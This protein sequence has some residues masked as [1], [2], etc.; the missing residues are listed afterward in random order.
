MIIVNK[1]ND[2]QIDKQMQKILKSFFKYITLPVSLPYAL[3]TGNDYFDWQNTAITCFLFPTKTVAKTNI[4]SNK[5]IKPGSKYLKTK[6]T[7]YIDKNSTSASGSPQQ[8]YQLT[9]YDDLPMVKLQREIQEQEKLREALKLKQEN[10]KTTAEAD[11]NKPKANID[12]QKQIAVQTSSEK[13]IDNP[14]KPVQGVVSQQPW[15]A[16]ISNKPWV[17]LPKQDKKLTVNSIKNP[18]LVSK[19]KQDKGF[20][21]PDRVEIAIDIGKKILKGSKKPG[22]DLP[23]K[24]ALEFDVV[25]DAI[26]DAGEALEKHVTSKVLSP[27]DNASFHNGAYNTAVGAKKVTDYLGPLMPYHV[28]ED[29]AYVTEKA[30]H[31]K[32]HDDLLKWL[33]R[34]PF[35]NGR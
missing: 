29:H 27:D 24:I 18:V 10:V 19:E 8:K 26:G 30:G 21:N 15:I 22:Y 25:K 17:H 7:V 13:Q 23:V 31:K 6:T 5:S 9:P 4:V 33:D 2:R 20:W 14:K 12:N 16:V 3:I 11:K 35:D 32:A 34:G 1:I 28:L